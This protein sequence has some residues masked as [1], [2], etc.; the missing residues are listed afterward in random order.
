MSKRHNRVPLRRLVATSVLALLMVATSSLAAL[1]GNSGSWSAAEDIE[2]APP[3]A[4]PDFNTPALDGCPFI[5]SDGK[6][7]FIA[8]DRPGG[9]GGLD[10][11]VSTRKNRNAP[12][13][14]PVNVGAPVNSEFNDFCP[15][16]GA[17]GKTF[18]FVSNR[19]GFCGTAP[20]ADIYVARLKN[21][22]QFVSVKHLGCVVNSSAD[23]HSPFPIKLQG[24][25]SVL[26][27]SSARQAD[28]TDTAGDHD[29]Y[30]SK[31]HRGVY[32]AATLVPGVN[33]EF[34]DGQPNVS[35]NGKELFF[36][37]NRPG[38]AGN[39]IY[40]ASRRTA[41]HQWSEP[42]NLGPTV[43]SP[44]SETRPSLSKDGRTLYFGST[45]AGSSDIYLTRR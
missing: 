28:A 19:P 38:A 31:S 30:M 32:Q 11:W 45:R 2:I 3:G 5:S 43:N 17:D 39:D 25:G 13:G 14:A 18:F 24:N 12:W 35:R 26:F 10:I 34:Q 20:N 7:F 4:H 37:S 44:A 23:E 29:I 1:A 42:I 40:S 6:K 22:N 8:S 41:R 27:F 36:Y 16:L 15:T 9:L 33:T 21:K